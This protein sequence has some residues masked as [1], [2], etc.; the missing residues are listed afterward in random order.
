MGFLKREDILVTLSASS[1]VLARRA[2]FRPARNFGWRQFERSDQ[3]TRIE[4]CS[5]S[6]RRR[7]AI[8]A[9]VVL[10]STEGRNR[11]K[12]DQPQALAPLYEINSCCRGRN[13]LLMSSF[14]YTNELVVFMGPH[15]MKPLSSH[16]LKSN[17]GPIYETSTR[18]NKF[19]HPRK[20]VRARFIE[21][22]KRP[23]PISS[24]GL[25]QN[26]P[27]DPPRG[28]RRARGL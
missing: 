18:W 25:D 14:L 2:L 11:K 5:R 21:R 4:F 3:K 15:G 16:G 7:E 8:V 1:R 22:C 9:R 20:L 23:Q 13:R 17:N 12:S 10:I 26:P 24:L 28:V 27:H 6:E 19:Y